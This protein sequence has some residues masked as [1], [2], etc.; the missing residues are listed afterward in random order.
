MSTWRETVAALVTYYTIIFAGRELMKGRKPIKLQSLFKV[1]N[2]SLTIIS[3][4]LL[5]LFLEQLVPTIARGGIFHSI[6]HYDGGWTDKLVIL[7][8]VSSFLAW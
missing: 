3:G 6:C 5:A 4:A 2:F 1:H 7:Y 8:Y